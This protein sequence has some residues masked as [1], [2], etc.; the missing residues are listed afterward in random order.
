MSPGCRKIL[1]GHKQSVCIQQT[2]FQVC[3]SSPLTV[4]AGEAE[5]ADLLGNVVPGPR[6]AQ[7]LQLGLQLIPHQQDPV[8]HGLHVILPTEGEK[9]VRPVR[10]RW[11]MKRGQ[12]QEWRVS[13]VKSGAGTELA[14]ARTASSCKSYTWNRQMSVTGAEVSDCPQQLI[15]MLGAY[16]SA[17][18]S[19]LLSVLL[20]T[21]AP[22]DGGLDQVVLTI[23]SIWDRMRVRFSPSWATTVRLPTLSSD[24][25]EMRDCVIATDKNK[26]G[27]RVST[28]C[29]FTKLFYKL[30]YKKK[31]K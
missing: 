30:F 22:W 26:D 17:K 27:R 24:N 11:E 25:K 15:D 12:W 7:T 20:T 3:V 9:R 8:C 16:H 14:E 10:K 4:Q 18:S 5:H 21:R 29:Y 6:G 19:G 2:D 1:V 28:S 23:F 13:R 31:I